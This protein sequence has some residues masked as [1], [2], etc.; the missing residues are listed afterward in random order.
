VSKWGTKAWLFRYMLDGR[1]REMGLGSVDTFSLKEARERARV[2]RQKVADRIDPIEAKRGERM[3]AKAENA[4]LISF[5]DA[6]AR[7]IDAHKAGW[8]NEKHAAQWEATLSSY[9]YP[10]LGELS[11]ADISTAHVLKVLEP[12]WTAKPE[13][14]SRVRGRIE[15]VLDWSTARGHRQGDNP[16][17]WR[18]HLDKLLPAKTKVRRVK[19]HDAMPYAA[20]PAFMATLRDMD[21]ISARA[22]EFTILTAART[23]ETIGARRPEV[24]AK[25]KLWTVPGER[26]KSGREHRVPLSDR[27]LEILQSL[28]CED[29]NDHLFIGARKGK[30]LSNMAMLELLRGIGA[31]G[32]TVHGFRSSFRDW[33]G[34]QTNFPRE[35]AEAALAH[36]LPDKT[37]A[38]YRRA[39]ALEKRR[40]LMA[41]WA[42]YCGKP[43]SRAGEVVALSG[44]R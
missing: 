18:G 33:A 5:K 31:N 42:S 9:V 39:D 21:S 36:V 28:P 16:A 14:A 2:A 29:G 4:K 20:V 32:L 10:T 13:T 3:A 15:A 43:T 27:A 7:Y 30:G 25:N 23:G 8:K 19:H 1:A 11:V 37:E 6:A 24:D 38:A 44:R 26:T 34:E 35:V 17:R 41:A 22:L 12:I 40:R